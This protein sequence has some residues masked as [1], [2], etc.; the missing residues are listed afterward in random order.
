M[1]T[2]LFRSPAAGYSIDP[3]SVFSFVPEL[4]V[5]DSGEEIAVAIFSVSGYEAQLNDHLVADLE[6]QKVWYE[7]G[8]DGEAL[9]L[10]AIAIQRPTY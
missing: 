3:N 1:R 2:F 10:T 8:R 6:I 5:M 4:P 9:E 7:F